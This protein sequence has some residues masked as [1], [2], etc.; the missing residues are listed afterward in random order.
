MEEIRRRRDDPAY[1]DRRV[2]LTLRAS[3]S[4]LVIVVEDEGAGFDTSTVPDQN[5]GE[6]LLRV[7]GRGLCLIRAFMDEVAYND[8]GNRI[9]M[10]KRT[11][12]SGGA[13]A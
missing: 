4:D 7:H 3:R 1:R 13:G 11:A 8:T 6:S 9:T 2:R 10:T 12:S 5:D